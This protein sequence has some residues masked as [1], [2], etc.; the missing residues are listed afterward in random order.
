MPYAIRRLRAYAG[1]NIH[2][3]RPGVLLR[4]SAPADKPRRLRAAIRDGAQSVG[5]V[6]AYLTTSSRPRSDGFLLEARFDTGEPEIGAAL[7][8]YIVDGLRAE[9][10]NDDEWDRDSPLFALQARRRAAALP[11]AALQLIAEA[12]RRGLPAL[13]LPDGQLQL[14]HGARGW[15]YSQGAE[16][17]WGRIGRIPIALISGQAQRAAAVARAAAAL[18]GAGAAVR[19][20][21][22]MS[23]SQ[24][25]DLL[26]DPAVE[27]AAIGLDSADL[28]ARGLPVDRCDQAII[29]DMEGP[30]PA[31]A[32]DDEEWLHALGL[33]MLIAAGPA[34]INRADARLQP[35]IPHAPHG[36]Q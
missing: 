17:P 1:P 16:P 21:D 32:D 8:R 34:Q 27:A 26:A 23:H 3:P 29:S 18:A 13:V 30:R 12:R 22:G 9:A 5:L 36:V 19:S 31:E 14:G 20:A 7:C 33:P 4:I 2:G 25:R 24:A 10:T 28:L 6:I 15:R 11:A 35:L